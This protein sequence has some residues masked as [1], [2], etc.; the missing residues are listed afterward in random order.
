M[1]SDMSKTSLFG[2]MTESGKI[3]S[4]F[5]FENVQLR[6]DN[7]LPPGYFYKQYLGEEEFEDYHLNNDDWNGPWEIDQDLACNCICL[8]CSGCTERQRQRPLAPPSY[9][10]NVEEDLYRRVLDEISASKRLPCGLFFCGHYADVR[11]PNVLIALGIVVLVL[12][13]MSIA[14]ILSP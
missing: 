12:G 4:R 1:V 13:A 6:V 14:A 9:V 7:T 10:L 11:H 3:Q 2:G 8:K 5:P